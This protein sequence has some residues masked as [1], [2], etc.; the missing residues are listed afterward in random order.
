MS[1]PQVL[2]VLI[3]LVLVYY[4]LG[5]IVSTITQLINESL[6]TRGVAL[7]KYLLQAAGAKAIDLQNLPQIK[8]LRPIRYANWW[9]VFGAGTEEKRV[10]K[11]P[12]STLV[13]GFFDVAGLSCKATFAP[14][15]LLATLNQLPESE[16]KQALLHWVGQGV[17]QI[18][19]LRDRASDYFN[20]ILSQAQATFKA[21]ARS[22]VIILS[23]LVTLILGTDTIQIAQDLWNDAALR[24]ATA[25]AATTATTGQAPG[26][27]TNPQLMPNNLATL[28]LRFGWWQSGN[29]E[30]AASSAIPQD[31]ILSIVLKVVGLLITAVAVS[32]GSSFWY[33]ILKR[34]TGQS[35]PTP[36]AGDGSSG[37]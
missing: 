20:G 3:G 23:L 2:E 34:L 7:E 1:F 29:F 35:G 27:G 31:P 36:A 24:A 28:P 14:D 19:D 5:S 30:L 10:E 6:E 16:A 18:D 37:S 32:Q 17:T 12:V 11:I 33:D 8:A 4:V 21:R 25:S 22:I 13:G 9:N 15:E 26:G